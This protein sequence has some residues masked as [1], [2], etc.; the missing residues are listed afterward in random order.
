MGS[1]RSI[2]HSIYNYSDGERTLYDIIDKIGFE[3]NLR[4]DPNNFNQIIKA[5]IKFGSIEN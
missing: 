2:I 3:Y 1:F 4:L 5:L